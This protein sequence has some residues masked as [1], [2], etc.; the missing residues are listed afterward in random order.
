M[1]E[2][3]EEVVQVVR[4]RAARRGRRRVTVQ[5]RVRKFCAL[6]AGSSLSDAE[7]VEVVVATDVLERRERVL[8]LD[9]LLG[10]RLARRHE[11]SRRTPSDG[12]QE[13]PPVQVQILR[14]DLVAR[15]VVRTP[16]QHEHSWR[17]GEFHE[18]SVERPNPSFRRTPESRVAGTAPNSREV[19]RSPDRRNAFRASDTLPAGGIGWCPTPAIR[20]YPDEPRSFSPAIDFD[21]IEDPARTGARRDIRRNG[22]RRSLGGAASPASAFHAGGGERPAGHVRVRA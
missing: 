13:L 21:A 7:L 14:G 4:R 12:A 22:L 10:T 6:R 1:R 9:A 2:R 18:R 8:R 17:N 16:D 5:G 19:P 11:G 3:A 15:N 20:I